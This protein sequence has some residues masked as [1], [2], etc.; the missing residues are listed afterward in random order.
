V[1]VTI[2]SSMRSVVG[3]NV[4]SI[5]LP[6]NVRGMAACSSDV[7]A[8]RWQ[9]PGGRQPRISGRPV[10]GTRKVHPLTWCS[11]VRAPVPSA[12]WSSPAQVAASASAH[13]P[14][15]NAAPGASPETSTTTVSPPS[16]P[17]VGEAVATWRPSAATAGADADPTPITARTRSEPSAARTFMGD[18]SVGPVVGRLYAGCGPSAGKLAN[19]TL[20]DPNV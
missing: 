9:V 14:S 7:Q 17:V 20:P 19:A 12:T 10:S 5:W 1:I 13:C 18:P 15:L 2:C 3:V 11:T 4:A 6:V 16:S 8:T